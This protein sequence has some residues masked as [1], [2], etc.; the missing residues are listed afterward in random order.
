M[1]VLT[2]TRVDT[3][4]ITQGQKAA[5]EGVG[6]DA[7]IEKYKM[8]LY[9][10]LVVEIDGILFNLLLEYHK[11]NTRITFHTKEAG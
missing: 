7:L 8:R 3:Q 4:E 10:S 9:E 11:P 1:Y 5:F 2:I 6:A